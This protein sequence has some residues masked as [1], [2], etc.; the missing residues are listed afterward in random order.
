[1]RIREFTAMI[2]RVREAWTGRN[3]SGVTA[4]LVAMMM[5]LL[6]GFAAVAVD[7]GILFNDRR[8]QQSAADGGALAAVQFA[9]T[10]LPTTNC[11]ALSGIDY[12]ACRGAEEAIDVVEGTLP[13]RYALVDWINCFDADKPVL[14]YTQSSTLSHCISFTDNL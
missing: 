13:G 5:F 8:Q 7:S 10:T 2:T 11:G 14:E 6:M 4:V 3:D 12:A 1:M 9:R